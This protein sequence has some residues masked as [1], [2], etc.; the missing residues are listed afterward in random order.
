MLSKVLKKMN[1]CD[2]NQT[3]IF[4]NDL[5]VPL[6]YY[7]GSCRLLMTVVDQRISKRTGRAALIVLSELACPRQSISFCGGLSSSLA[8]NW[9]YGSILKEFISLLSSRVSRDRKFAPFVDPCITLAFISIAGLEM[10]IQEN[11]QFC[12]E[13]TH[14]HPKQTC[15]KVIGMWTKFSKSNERH[16]FRT[17]IYR[18]IHVLMWKL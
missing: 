3:A 1:L 13:Q 11:S 9:Q 4:L 16:P 17:I 5:T 10:R 15:T 7:I 12:C 8:L 14:V 18:E 6:N 2:A